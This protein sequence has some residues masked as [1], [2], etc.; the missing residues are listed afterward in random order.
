[1]PLGSE[2]A[3][4]LAGPNGTPLIGEL[5]APA[6]PAGGVSCAKACPCRYK[7]PSTARTSAVMR[8]IRPSGEL[9]D[10]VRGAL[11]QTRSSTSTCDVSLGSHLQTSQSACRI[12]A[13]RPKGDIQ[14]RYRSETVL[15]V[16]VKTTSENCVHARQCRSNPV[17]GPCLP[18]TGI[19]QSA[20]RDYRRFRS[21]IAESGSIETERRTAKSRV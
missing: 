7:L 19:F 3:L 13:S 20:A 21:Q 6:D 14:L 18:K 9:Q 11:P 17:S 2:M 1:M 15:M 5:P 10:E 4:G 12:S 16:L 8:D